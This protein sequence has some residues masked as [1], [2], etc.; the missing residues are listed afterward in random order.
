MKKKSIIKCTVNYK[1]TKNA[2]DH[3][4]T[5]VMMRISIMLKKKTFGMTFFMTLSSVTLK[6]FV[7]YY[8]D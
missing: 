8:H 7:G 5:R 2:I 6:K 1:N 3:N 4:H